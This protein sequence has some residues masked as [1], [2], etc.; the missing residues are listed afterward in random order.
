L[1]HRIIQGAKDI[2]FSSMLIEFCISARVI[3]GSGKAHLTLLRVAEISIGV[4]EYS[5]YAKG[6]IKSSEGP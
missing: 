4:E 1:D 2:E 3:F 5:Q 6:I